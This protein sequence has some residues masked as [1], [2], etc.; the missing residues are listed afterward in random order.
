MMNDAHTHVTDNEYL[1]E[2]TGTQDQSSTLVRTRPTLPAMNVNDWERIASLAA[3]LTG[4][5]L[6]SRRLLIYLAL[7]ALS[8]YLLYRGLTG[9]CF[10][11]AKANLSTR[12]GN[13]RDDNSDES[14][15]AS[16]SERWRSQSHDIVEEAS[17]ESF[18]A[19]DPPAFN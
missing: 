16:V 7:A 19:S 10:V 2:T 4:F 18:P 14:T 12:S 13:V 3:G 1:D 15:M 8:G 11:Y 17:W 9:F 5:F 6:L